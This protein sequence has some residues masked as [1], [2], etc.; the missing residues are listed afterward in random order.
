MRNGGFGAVV[1]NPP[2]I[3]GKKVSG[4][5]GID[6]R[7]YL[8][9]HIARGKPGNAD[10]CSYFLLRDLSVAPH[11]RVGIIATNTIA[12]GDTRE[13][14]LDQVVDIGWTVY[15]AEKSQPWPGP[16]ALEVSLVWAGH[17]GRQETRILDGNQ[18][19]SITP[20]L[21]PPSRIIGNPYRLI[22]NEGQSFQGS[23]V[24]GTGF[25]LA[26][27]EAQELIA[28]NPQNNAVLFPYLNGE[29]LTSR[30]DCSA[31]RW[32]INF[33]DWPIERAQQYV[34]CF[35][36]I[37][38]KV[39]EFRARSNRK[40]YRDRWWQ[41]AERQ[42][43]LHR[44]IVGLDS[45]IVIALA[46]K[47]GMPVRV[48]AGSVFSHA[49]GVFVN[50]RF[51]E[52]ALLSSSIHF[53]WWTTKGESTLETRLR[54]TP[55]DGFETFPQPELTGRMDQAAKN[56]DTFRRTLMKG[57]RVGLTALYNL[58]HDSAVQDD[59]IAQL[60]G[61]GVEI[62]EAVRQAYSL[63]EERETGIRE[64]EARV[65]SA[66]LPSWHEIELGHGFHETRQGMRFTISPQARVDVLDK[67]L[68]LNHY[69]YRQEVERGLHSR[70]RVPK[71]KAAAPVNPPT[72]VFDD[73]ALF[74][75]EGTMF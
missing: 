8:K 46:S 15:R 61:I 52:L 3:G 10:L 72:D 14:G 2:F 50:N 5:L 28:Q 37:T 32:I 33:H 13:V 6:Y 68:A 60:R 27:D 41:Y 1:S 51:A 43:A 56:L 7:E 63:D 21:G 38:E 54:Y 12:Q 11:G 22:S 24:L 16:A 73:G 57:R 47:I 19:T 48:A 9:Q 42:P 30:W 39:K 35:Q 44:A 18:V 69:R 67:L 31:S 66:P 75:P 40:V 4:A 49:L 45:V 34:E 29:D 71:K 70:R 64:F 26:P 25:I 55:S 74:R 23:V 53:D 62:D 17:P 59:D 36:I 20:S 58:V 65:A